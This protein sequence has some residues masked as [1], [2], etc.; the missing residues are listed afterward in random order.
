MLLNSN[1]MIK[2]LPIDKN[3][4]DMISPIID[5]TNSN[6]SFMTSLNGELDEEHANI[7]FTGGNGGSKPV[8]RSLSE[9]KKKYVAA[10]Q[11]WKCK[12]CKSK[13]SAYF[14]VDHIVS[15]QY[16]GNNNVENLSALCSE[17]HRSKTA[18]EKM[19][20]EN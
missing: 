8:K 19:N 18:L 15:L 14:E 1:E 17:C 11:D 9:T 6:N 4:M 2:Y 16:G 3:S 5:F 13:L 12:R 20:H 10:S 7:T